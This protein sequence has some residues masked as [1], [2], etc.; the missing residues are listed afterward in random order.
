MEDHLRLA[1]HAATLS[2]EE[3]LS[4]RLTI[5]NDQLTPAQEALLGELVL[6]HL[7]DLAG[8]KCRHVGHAGFTTSHQEAPDA[9]V[10]TLR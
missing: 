8:G 5:A 6:R 7:D 3:L 4:A 9:C 2:D 10:R 1:A